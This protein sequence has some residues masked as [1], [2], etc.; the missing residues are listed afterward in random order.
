MNFARSALKVRGVVASLFFA[1]IALVQLALE[2]DARADEKPIVIST[3]VLADHP[4]NQCAPGQALGAGV[5]GHEKG[6]C[7]RMFTDNTIDQ[8]NDDGYSR[9]ADRDNDSFWKSNPYLDSHFTA[10]SDDGHP[11]WVVIDLDARK[12]VNA[13]RI[14]WGTPYATQYRVE[15][16]PGD[17]PM[18]LHTDDDQDWQPFAHGNVD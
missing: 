11:Q 8:A 7:A 18:H 4:V 3:T 6:D 12:P 17:D 16:W 9:I 5:D 15:Y 2:T 10:E 1:A 14:L 13:I